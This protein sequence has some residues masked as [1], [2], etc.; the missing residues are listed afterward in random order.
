[1]LLGCGLATYLLQCTRQHW[2]IASIPE[3][4]GMAAI[5]G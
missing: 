3:V 1:M 2:H 5:E 4:L